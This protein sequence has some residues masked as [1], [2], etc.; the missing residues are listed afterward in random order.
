M[1]SL[2][3]ELIRAIVEE[4]DDVESWKM[5][6]LVATIFREHAQRSL[7]WSLN[8]GGDDDK[9]S[10][11]TWS[12]LQESPHLARYF[13][14]LLYIPPSEEVS[15]E[16]LYALC[17]VL[18][19]LSNVRQCYFIGDPD[20]EN[21]CSW[22]DIPPQLAI[23]SVKFIRRQ[24]RLQEL[25]IVSIGGLPSDTLIQFFGVAP[26]LSLLQTTVDIT[27]TVGD[28]PSPV[29]SVVQNLCLLASSDMSVVLLTA[30]FLPH[31]TGI[32]KLWVQPDVEKPDER[33]S[34]F[35]QNLD[36]L[37]LECKV[38]PS[39]VVPP[40]PQL[41]FLQSAELSFDFDDRDEPWFVGHL[42]AILTAASDALK[43]ICI[44]YDP[45]PS[46]LLNHSSTPETMAAVEGA[47][48]GSAFSPRVRWR[49]DVDA[50][51][52]AEE[53][54][55]GFIASLQDGMPKLHEQG[56]LI[57]E[58]YSADDGFGNWTLR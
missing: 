27:T 28:P 34:T 43:E 3:P 42:T 36:H 46:S 4:I 41:P 57:I 21:I 15:F 44:T 1:N 53:F 38:K 26:T 30:Q 24:T 49:V 52:E 37:S 14:R 39:S 10:T 35:A 47:I 11:A 12:L 9:S 29:D 54:F 18:D 31:L 48:V 16:E 32:R 13:K 7:L 19:R 58:R 25:H 22:S 56:R 55:S 33:I 17:A 23:A 50:L 40:L 5:C 51:S 45:F 2:P 6:A 20:L 8:L